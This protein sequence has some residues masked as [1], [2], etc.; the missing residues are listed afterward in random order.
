MIQIYHNPR[1]GKSRCGIDILEKSGKEFE[2][3]KYLDKKFSKSEL[4]TVLKKLKMKPIDIVRQNEAIWKEQFK[5]KTAS[6]NEIL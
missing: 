6:D 5:G 3:I 2:V 1:C 4:K